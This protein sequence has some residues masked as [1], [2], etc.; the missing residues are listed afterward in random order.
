MSVL[1]PEVADEPRR[2]GERIGDSGVV[3]TFREILGL[4]GPFKGTRI[5]SV[6][7]DDQAVR[8]FVDGGALGKLGLVVVAG[9]TEGAIAVNEHL[10]LRYSGK[11]LSRAGQMF[12]EHGKRRLARRSLEELMDLVVLPAPKLD[13]S[14]PDNPTSVAFGYASPEGWNTFFE[15]QESYRGYCGGIMGRIATVH[16]ADPEC[17]ASNA[18]I[19]DGTVNFFQ[20]LAQEPQQSHGAYLETDLD[21]LDVIKGGDKKLEETLDRLAPYRDDIDAVLVASTCISLVTGDDMDGAA[22]KLEAKVKLPVISVGNVK[23]PLAVLLDT[24]GRREGFYLDGESRGH[25]LLVGFP[26]IRGHREVEGLLDACGIRRRATLLP[27]VDVEEL[28]MH[29]AAEVMVMYPCRWQRSSAEGLIA[30]IPLPRIEPMPPFG[31]EGTRRYCEAIAD[32]LGMREAV[33]RELPERIAALT[34]D[35]ESLR[36]EAKELTLGFVANADAMKRL[37][38]A[39][40]LVGVPIVPLLREMGFRLHILRHVRPDDR[41]VATSTDGGAVTIE[42]FR[43]P[44]ELEA[45]LRASP[46]HA[47]YSDMSADRRLTRTGKAGFSVRDLELGPSGAVRSLRRL[48]AKARLPFYRKYAA[49]FG[50]PFSTRSP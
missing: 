38:E 37:R 46:A 43:T 11:T 3:E 21:D 25:Y 4:P 22:A 35:W 24:L 8:V 34:P 6:L 23:N 2:T 45:L 13:L 1:F 28:R 32:A 12:V 19:H 49:H 31:V 7:A 41:S 20:F 26:P 42:P 48:L 5:T 36:S 9:D 47:F 29:R 10:A 15:G 27:V 16:H 50:R 18:R 33:D 30:N 40:E 14:P 17:A 39:S 44:A